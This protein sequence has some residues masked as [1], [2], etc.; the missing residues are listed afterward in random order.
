[1]CEGGDGMG[2][3]SVTGGQTCALPIFQGDVLAASRA[4]RLLADRIVADR[5]SQPRA[6]HAWPPEVHPAFVLRLLQRSQEQDDAFELRRELEAALAATGR[7]IETAI[8]SEG[9]HQASEQAA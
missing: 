7:S 2:D 9:R 3:W 6:A 1:L 4:H 5:E 8:A